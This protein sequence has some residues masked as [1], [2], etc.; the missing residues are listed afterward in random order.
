M[1]IGL[2]HPIVASASPLSS[3][4]D[5]IRRLED[6]GAA[7]VVMFSLF[8]EQIQ[9][10]NAVFEHMLEHGTDSFAESLSYFPEAGDYSVGPES[11]L[12]LLRRAA[13]A[14]EI[15]IFGSLNGITNEGWID[16]ARQMEEAGARGIELNVYYI[17]A[18]VH[19]TGRQVEAHY[20]EIARA[21]KQ[22][23][24]VPVAVKLSPFFSSIGNMVSDLDALGVDGLV[25]FNRFYQPDFDVER[26]EVA[27][28][29]SLSS[30]EEIRVPLL[31]IGILYGRVK[32]SLAATRGVQDSNEVVKYLLAGADVVMTASALLRN[33]TA[34]LRTLRDGLQEWMERHG[35]D[36]LERMRGI[37]SQQNVA[38]PTAF[39]RAN[40][41]RILER[42]K[43]PYIPY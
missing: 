25:L 43:N 28:T 16:Y 4:L 41:I 30:P 27:P 8:E 40:Y 2:Q 23:V 22:A 10:E 7:A 3:T 35:I 6:D 17:P 18:D 1:G 29:L 37:M 26:L 21:V 39:E 33:G 19:L 31:W 12:E 20:L 5:G 42:Y 36:A 32:A 15:P 13:E 34:H 24:T 9:H 11:Y 38:D 14:V